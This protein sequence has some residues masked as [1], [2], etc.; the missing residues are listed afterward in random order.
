MPLWRGVAFTFEKKVLRK[1]KINRSLNEL[2]TVSLFHYILS[3]KDENIKPCGN[4][5][6]EVLETYD[7]ETSNHR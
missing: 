7:K 5:A 6:L 3:M 2:D 4:R 1:F